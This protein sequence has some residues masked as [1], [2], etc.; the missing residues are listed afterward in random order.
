[1]KILLAPDSF[2]GSAT[3]KEVAL[4]MEKGI[5]QMIP[6]AEIMKAP[7]SDGGEGMSL[8]LT[9]K[10]GGMLKKAMVKGPLGDEIESYYGIIDNGGTAVMDV[11]SVIGL[12]LIPE[13]KRN[14]LKT[15][16]EGVGQLIS[17]ILNDDVDR[18]II[19]LGGSSTV[20]GGTGMAQ[21][22]GVIFYSEEKNW[23][24]CVVVS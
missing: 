10:S 8:I 21:K 24:E 19:G 14:P 22:L 18:I 6:E 11:A 20:D 1:M 23:R 2:K 5:K 16:T 4:A 12:P 7:L 3:S 15:S 17:E 9:E 13:E